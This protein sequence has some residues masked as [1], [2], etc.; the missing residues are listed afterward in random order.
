MLEGRERREGGRTRPPP[1][2]F[3]GE[4]GLVFVS[5]N[6]VSFETASGLT[7]THTSMFVL[8]TAPSSSPTGE[9][10]VVMFARAAMSSDV[11]CFLYFYV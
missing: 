7:R 9:R 8:R 11:A 6:L 10:D 5:K 1:P 4:E 3:A 2:T